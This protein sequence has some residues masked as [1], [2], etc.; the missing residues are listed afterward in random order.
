MTKMFSIPMV[1]S[2]DS[3]GERSYDIYSRLLKDRIIMIDGEIE[4][5][6]AS[7]VVAEL[8]YL[9]S[10]SETEPIHIYISSPGGY[11]SAG[12]SICS[13]MKLIKPPVYVTAHGSVAS[14]ASV[15][16]SCGEKG[17]R[18][19]LPN[20]R[21]MLHQV[22]SGNEGNIQDMRVEMKETERINKI[23]IQTLADNC[24][25]TYEEIEKATERNLWMD[26][27]EALKFGIVDKIL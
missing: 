11:C 8:L 6:M 17:N 25:K 16:L 13:T 21:V 15:I 26:E 18:Y 19:I 3:D 12:F 20:T 14:M 27:N 10:E 22:S 1:V 23:A 4:P 9:Q 5:K 7:V 24:G 2:K